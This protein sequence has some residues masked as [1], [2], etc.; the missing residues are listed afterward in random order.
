MEGIT[1]TLRRCLLA[2]AAFAAVAV[3]ATAWL[4][5]T[6]VASNPNT[7]LINGDSV[8]PAEPE[9]EVGP[10]LKEGVPISLEQYA[11]ERAGFSVTIVPGSVWKTMSAAEF[12]QYQVLIVGDP[13]CG[14]L[15]ASVSESVGNWAPA[16]MGAGSG[17]IVGNRTVIGTDPED[18]Y[19][20][21]DGHAP[22]QV[23]GDPSTSGAEHLVESAIKFAG[24]VPGAT[25]ISYDTSCGEGEPENFYP[26]QLQQISTG[27]GVWEMGED[28]ACSAEIALIA[29]NPSFSTLT[30]EDLEGWHCSAH[31]SFKSFPAD[32]HALALT[33]PAS[34]LGQVCGTDIE[35]KEPHCGNAYVLVAGG[36]VIVENA[37]IKLQPTSGSQP[38]GGSHTV[39]ATVEEEAHEEP[40]S[41]LAGSLHVAV[42]KVVNFAVTGRNNGVT[43][44]CTTGAGEPDPECKTDANGQ[45]KFTYP[46]TNGAGLDTINASVSLPNGLQTAAVGWEWIGEPVVTPT[47]TPT[48]AS[49]PAPATQVLAS[50]ATVASTGSAHIASS[51]ACVASS[52]YIASVKGKG[53]SSVTYSLDGHKVGT[54]KHADSH[55]AFSLRV[56]VGSGS[57]RLSMRVTFSSGAHTAPLTLHRTLARCAARHVTPRFTG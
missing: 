26:E 37:F 3:P 4:P 40:T 33:L 32:W 7:A 47:P 1:K 15:P 6:A 38:A 30:H 52:G 43:G 35:T 20:Y 44:V 29:S 54:V 12:A 46:D 53:I 55:G 34:G 22:P 2:G 45:V 24:S 5:A 50:K 25:G 10:I 42:G 21:G 19:Q 57:H 9:K 36:G 56:H 13:N 8:E 28:P 16:V 14:G 18:H 39:T 51:R 11:A 27:P 17:G 49:T 23:P 31:V 41:R 48:P